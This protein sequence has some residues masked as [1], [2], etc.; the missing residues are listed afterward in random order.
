VYARTAHAE[1]ILDVEV[2]KDVKAI[3]KDNPIEVSPRGRGSEFGFTAAQ[4]EEASRSGEELHSQ[5][6]ISY[7]PT[8]R[9]KAASTNRCA[10]RRPPRSRKGQTAGYWLARSRAGCRGKYCHTHSFT[11]WAA[12][13]AA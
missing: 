3:F 12:G 10:S 6:T 9:M 1:F 11:Q 13:A 5:Y 2:F 7:N 8:T 4:L